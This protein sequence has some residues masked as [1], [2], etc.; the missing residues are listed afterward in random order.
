[1][2]RRYLLVLAAFLLL[3]LAVRPPTPAAQGHN[4]AA[5]AAPTL[6]WQRGGCFGNYCQTR[7]V[8][9]AAGGGRPR[10]RRPGRG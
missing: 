1:M 8:L 6:K 9:V 2:H 3:A 4:L 10:R 5:I 7:L